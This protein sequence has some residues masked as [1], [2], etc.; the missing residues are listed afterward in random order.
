M[1]GV[2]LVEAGIYQPL[3]LIEGI[4]GGVN[5]AAAVV[6]PERLV[7]AGTQSLDDRCQM[8]RIDAVTTHGRV[9]AHG[10]ETRP[11]EKSTTQR[12]AGDDLI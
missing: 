5:Q 11:I 6:K 1:D 2:V 10:F 7:D 8:P 9:S 3:I 4:P 12:M